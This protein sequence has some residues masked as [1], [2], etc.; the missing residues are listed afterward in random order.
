MKYKNKR[1]EKQKNAHKNK[2]KN[3]KSKNCNF[4][5]YHIGK[6]SDVKL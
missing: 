3:K 4:A 1:I 5:L 2:N 6:E